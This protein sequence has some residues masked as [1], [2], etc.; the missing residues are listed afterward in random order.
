MEF[1]F[2]GTVALVVDGVVADPGPARQ[3]CVLAALAVD[4][5]Q[6]VSRDR[7]IQRVW[8][9]DPPLRARETLVNYVS[10]LRRVLAA[11][12]ATI[13]RRP[14]AYALRADPLAVDIH[15]FRR[16]CSRAR[17][18]TGRTAAGLLEQATALWHGEALTGLTGDWATTERD[19][20][21]QERQDAE[22]DLTDALLDLGHG[23]DLVAG[24]AVRA[25]GHPLDERAAGQY[26]LALHRA[27]RTADALA[28][29]RLVRDRLV[30]DLG[31]DPGAALQDLHRRILTPGPA[32]TVRPRAAR[33]VVTPRQLPA[34]PAPFVGRG[35]LL[36]ELDA[37]STTVSAVAG[38]GGIG[39][40]ALAL[41]WAHQRIDR[42]PDG[43]L[44]VDLRGSGPGAAM[45]PSAAL[46]GVLDAL[47]VEHDQVPSDLHARAVLFRSLV[48]GHRV[49]LLLDDAADTAQVVP[50]LPG[51]GSCT[52]VVTS[53]N[54]LPGLLAGH[55]ARHIPVH[56][57]DDADAR[58]LLTGKLGRART[59]AEP[60]AVGEFVR[61]CGGFPLALGV[62]AGHALTR[63]TATL[64][65]LVAEIRGPGLRALVHASLI[66]QDLTGRYAL[67]DLVQRHAAAT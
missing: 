44:F 39:K 52:V 53:R 4:V 10:R 22:W 19:Q 65:A 60:E 37:T 55:A 58:V 3:R 35:E 48:A 41:H 27:G 33:R 34:A 12:G 1:R 20:L 59:G 63:P 45:E 49:L 29:F 38:A 51:S 56:V 30:D 13:A 9:G 16:L 47:G 50:L 43:Q 24:L 7:L 26:M 6:D 2:L 67:H 28:H 8:G 31:T 5:D 42:F 57:L 40:T 11:G 25:A 21:H 54:V 62:V 61:L 32:L 23:E 36:D 46:R 64:A 18:E 66:E 14:G 15:R 17:A